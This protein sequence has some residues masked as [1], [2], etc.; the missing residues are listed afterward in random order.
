MIV[1]A[2]HMQGAYRVTRVR[3]ADGST[4]TMRVPFDFDLPENEGR[5]YRPGWKAEP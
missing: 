4:F 5:R 1:V 3:R 2:P